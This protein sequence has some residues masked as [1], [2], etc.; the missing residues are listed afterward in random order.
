MDDH[1]SKHLKTYIYE[2][3]SLIFRTKLCAF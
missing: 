3:K 2:N 1:I